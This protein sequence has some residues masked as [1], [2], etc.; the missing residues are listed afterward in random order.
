MQCN[1]NRTDMLSHTNYR[2]LSSPE[3]VQ[4]LKGLHVAYCAKHQKVIRLN[5]QVEKLMEKEG[6]EVDE[7][8]HD[9]LLKSTNVNQKDESQFARIFWESQCKAASLKNAKS[10]RWHPL[11]IRWCL[12]LKHLSG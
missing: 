3:K 11:M 9:H 2:F 7:E 4:R 5:Q 12:Y 6:V 8:L 10:M 1:P